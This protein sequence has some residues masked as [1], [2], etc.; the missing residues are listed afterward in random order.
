MFQSRHSWLWRAQPA[1]RREAFSQDIFFFFP[2]F[3]QNW[4]IFSKAASAAQRAVLIPLGLLQHSRAGG[5]TLTPQLAG[6]CR[7][8]LY[9]LRPSPPTA[10]THLHR[11]SPRDYFLPDKPHRQITDIKDAGQIW[12][13]FCKPQ[14]EWR[15]EITFQLPSPPWLGSK[16]KHL[17]E[18]YQNYP[19]WVLWATAGTA[20]KSHGKREVL[21]LSV[22]E[23]LFT[24]TAASDGSRRACSLPVPNL[25]AGTQNGTGGEAKPKSRKLDKMILPENSPKYHWWLQG[26]EMRQEPASR[27]SQRQAGAQAPARGGPAHQRALD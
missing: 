22:W 10:V 21:V 1:S 5:W 12:K 19:K 2:Y 23:Q 26:E 15:E 16:S 24:G 11:K 8:L 4:C 18:K 20:L 9:F 3:A 27:A 25:Q 7:Q 17:L 13:W 6:R 14:N